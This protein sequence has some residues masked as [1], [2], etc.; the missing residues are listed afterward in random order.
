LVW[1]VKNYID[2]HD[3]DCESVPELT[4]KNVVS[5]LIST[6]SEQNLNQ[7]LHANGS[8]PSRKVIA[9]AKN[10]LKELS[11]TSNSN[12]NIM[13]DVG[14]AV[15]IEKYDATTRQDYDDEVLLLSP[16]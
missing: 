15:N 10:R 8:K 12:S 2:V 9:N 11:S 7:T 16:S 3:I 6:G 14:V 4:T 5:I 13:N 1:K